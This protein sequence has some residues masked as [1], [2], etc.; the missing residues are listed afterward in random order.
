MY[1][2]VRYNGLSCVEA[3][4]I[5]ARTVSIEITLTADNKYKSLMIYVGGC[6]ALSGDG[7]A[8]GDGQ[9]SVRQNHG[10]TKSWT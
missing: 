2:F 6:A 8:V 10:I 4:K 7:Q 3:S 1:V 9:R 5:M